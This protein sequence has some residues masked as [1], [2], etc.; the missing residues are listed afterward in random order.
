MVQ[1]FSTA[2]HYDH[3]WSRVQV[4]MWQ[5][6]PNPQCAH[7]VSVDV[8]DRSVHPETGVIRTERLV[9][10]K[11]AAPGWA[12]R[13]LGGTEDAYV[14]EVSFVDP[15]TKKTWIHSTNLSLCEYMTVVEKIT[16]VPSTSFPHTR[17]HF[18]QTAEIQA[19]T[20]LWKTVGQKIEQMSLDRFKQNAIR[21]KEGFEGVL[22]TLFGEDNMQDISS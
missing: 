4:G 1:Y 13:F 7:V 21:G 3:P 18:H 20:K 12:I 10:C 2:F 14:R 8:I 17:T 19:R 22:R 9:G 5:K 15:R 16:Y 6:Y 11:Q